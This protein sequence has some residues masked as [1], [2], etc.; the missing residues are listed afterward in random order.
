M[1]ELIRDIETLVMKHKF[2]I[3]ALIA[4]IFVISNYNEMKQGFIDGY[5]E[6]RGIEKSKK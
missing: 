2:T 4:L 6:V 1:K 3:I 5:T